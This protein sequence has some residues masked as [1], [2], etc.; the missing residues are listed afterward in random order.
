MIALMF[1]RDYLIIVQCRCIRILGF[2]AKIIQNCDYCVDIKNSFIVF[3]HIDIDMLCLRLSS[4]EFHNRGPKYETA[5]CR[6][7]VRIYKNSSRQLEQVLE[8]REENDQI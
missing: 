2:D 8:Y 3:L 6:C 7:L 5:A 4:R 1:N